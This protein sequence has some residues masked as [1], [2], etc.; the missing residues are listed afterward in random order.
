LNRRLRQQVVKKGKFYI[1]QTTLAGSQWLRSTI[2][3][4]FTTNAHWE[5]LLEHIRSFCKTEDDLP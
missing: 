1:V 3:N 5:S 4:P 2:A